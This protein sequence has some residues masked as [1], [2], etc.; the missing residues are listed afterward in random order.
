M[1]DLKKD[2]QK[3]PKINLEMN[4]SLSSDKWVREALDAAF[5]DEEPKKPKKK[6]PEDS[7]E[8][9]F[10]RNWKWLALEAGAAL[11]V[12]LLV[13]NLIIGVPRIT[14]NSME[15]NFCSGDRIV[16]FRL[17]RNIEKG[18]IIVFK[19]KKGEKLI[20]R[21]VATAGD[22]VDVSRQDGLYINGTKVEE[23]YVYTAT[24]ITDE[25]ME[26]PVTVREDCYFVLGDNRVNSK[27][28]RSK[29]VGLVEKKDIVGRVVLDIKKV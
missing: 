9:L 10:K 14:G 24:A 15:P 23:D 29:E 6:E 17:A 26:Y 4:E 22:T 8:N 16:I 19:T 2:L 13:F 18:D 28:S 5:K 3:T 12:V 20:K 25:T 7:K 21:V 11:L 1:I 27:D